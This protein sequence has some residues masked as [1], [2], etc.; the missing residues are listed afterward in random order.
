[1]KFVNIDMDLLRALVF[2]SNTQGFTKAAQQLFRTQSAISLQ[3][4]KLEQLTNS[5]LLERG[6]DIHL[7]PAGLKVYE[8][9]LKIL[10][11]NDDLVSLF[12]CDT[13]SFEPKISLPE[14]H[15]S[16]LIKT[17]IGNPVIASNQ[18]H[19]V[20]VFSDQASKLIDQHQLDMAFILHTELPGGIEVSKVPLSWVSATGST[21]YHGCVI[22]LVL[23]PEGSLIRFIAQQALNYL[24]H[25]STV[26]S[27]ATEHNVL[28][29]VIIAGKGIGVMPTHTIPEGLLIITD[30]QLPLLPS[31]NLYI[32][33]PEHADAR[34]I[35]LA[36]AFADAYRLG[37][38]VI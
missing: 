30:E 5:Q 26:I 35:K 24:D 31:P 25:P 29:D 16:H 6:K 9:A 2:V 15:D 4:K 38:C 14:H 22:A 17:L 23:P 10:T 32:K 37:I 20:S 3:I 21:V 18:C 27:S 11:L 28:S 33:L 7:T 36:P 1:M 12:N 13:S 8:Y 19:F 34:L